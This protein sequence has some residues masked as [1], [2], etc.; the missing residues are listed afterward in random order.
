AALDGL[1]RRERSALLETAAGFDLL[2]DLGDELARA[3]VDRPPAQLGDSDAIRP[4]LD[5][6]PDELRDARDGGK[7]YIA[8]LQTGE[9]QP[10]AR[11]T[12]GRTSPTA[13]ASG[14]KGAATP[15]SSG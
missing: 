15:W 5:R 2:A 9:R 8:G 10:T 6:A 14:W 1:E 3:L 7:A 4:G 11:T 12:C 13:S